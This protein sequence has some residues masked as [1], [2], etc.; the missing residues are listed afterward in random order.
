MLSFFDAAF[1]LSFSSSSQP[2]PYDFLM[3]PTQSFFTQTFKLL[4]LITFCLGV[5][6]ALRIAVSAIAVFYSK[7]YDL[8]PCPVDLNYFLPW[9]S[10]STTDAVSAIQD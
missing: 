10:G 5:V 7:F 2:R 1:M 3:A 6:V 9:C 4:T 8:D